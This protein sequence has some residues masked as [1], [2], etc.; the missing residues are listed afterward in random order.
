MNIEKKKHFQRFPLSHQR[1]PEIIS[2]LMT[3][4]SEI[5]MKK[6][7]LD[8]IA[9]SNNNKMKSSLIKVIGYGKLVKFN[10]RHKSKMNLIKEL[11]TQKTNR[12]RHY[13]QN[14]NEIKKKRES[15]KE[16]MLSFN[17]KR[18]NTQCRMIEDNTFTDNG[19]DN[20]MDNRSNNH[21]SENN[22]LSLS[23]CSFPIKKQTNHCVNKQS[24]K[25]NNNLH[26]RSTLYSPPFMN[27]YTNMN[28][29]M[30]ANMNRQ[31]SE[32]IKNIISINKETYKEAIRLKEELAFEKEKDAQWMLKS[33]KAKYHFVDKDMSLLL[34]NEENNMKNRSRNP[35]LNKYEL[36]TKNIIT[37]SNQIS[38]TSSEDIYK[39]KRSFGD[40]MGLKITMNG[41]VIKF[42][43]K[44]KRIKH[45]SAP[46]WVKQVIKDQKKKY[47][48][49]KDLSHKIKRHAKYIQ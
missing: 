47:K 2:Q 15:N 24:A 17:R 43:K 6:R 12:M 32:Q 29:N 39:L 9:V 10:T 27:T 45:Y 25:G 31:N 21:L 33:E 11:M 16:L 7:N 30:S 8:L 20:D 1:N 46:E 37:Q 22:Q 42:E 48:L 49:V 44:Y 34:Q 13:L 18:V 36:K 5:E 19:N 14:F 28:M 35:M 3:F 26:L 38:K 41:N 4:K 40:Q 23:L